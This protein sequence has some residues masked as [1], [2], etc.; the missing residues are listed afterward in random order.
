MYKAIKQFGINKNCRILDPS[1]G[2]GKFLGRLPEELEYSSITAIEKDSLTGRLARK[3]YPNAN[4]EIKG[5]EDTVLNNNYYD[6]AISNIPFRRFSEFLI[7][8][9]MIA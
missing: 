3:I 8:T 9:M 1:T 4:I 7:E 6:I 5:Y 2:V